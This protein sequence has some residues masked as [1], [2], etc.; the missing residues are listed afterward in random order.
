MLKWWQQRSHA[1]Y[2]VSFVIMMVS[3]VL[4]YIA[5][6]GGQ[7]AWMVVSL[8]GFILANLLLLLVR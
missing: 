2:L 8:A 4:M 5:V 6:K 7:P 1:V 3:P